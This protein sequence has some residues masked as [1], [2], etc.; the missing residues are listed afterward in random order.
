MLS[1]RDQPQ[2]Q[3]Q[4]HVDITSTH[5]PNDKHIS[6]SLINGARGS[7]VITGP[8]H[9]SLYALNLSLREVKGL[10]ALG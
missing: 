5:L 8:P 4:Y 10:T 3:V 2:A 6:V 7:V 1:V 9:Q